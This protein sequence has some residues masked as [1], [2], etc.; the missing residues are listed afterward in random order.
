M[1][2]NVARAVAGGFAGTAL[3]TGMMYLVAPMMGVRM[4]IAAMLAS[5]LGGSWTAGLAMH[6]M[7]GAVVFPMAFLLLQRWLPGSA[8]VRGVLLG[9]GLWMIAQVMVMPMMGAGFFS[10]NAGG[11]MAA[12]ASLAGHVVYGSTLG[13]ITGAKDRVA[14]HA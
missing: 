7:N 11:A 9:T 3:M 1:R 12:M 13:A 2:T 14:A 8:T 5:M 4:D 10:A 6:F